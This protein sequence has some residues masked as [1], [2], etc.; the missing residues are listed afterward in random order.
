MIC[1]KVLSR[2]PVKILLFVF[3]VSSLIG[4]MNRSVPVQQ[5]YPQDEFLARERQIGDVKFRYRVYV[6]ANRHRDEK[7]PVMLYSLNNHEDGPL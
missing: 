1:R 3:L 2:R 5:P 4:C 7:L 6:P